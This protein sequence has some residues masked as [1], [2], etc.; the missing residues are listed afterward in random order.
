MAANLIIAAMGRSY[1]DEMVHANTPCHECMLTHMC[2][3]SS[4]IAR[5]TLIAFTTIQCLT[6][7]IT[8]TFFR[9]CPGSIRP[10]WI[11]TNVL[12]V[13][14]CK[15]GDPVAFSVLVEVNDALIHVTSK[16]YQAPEN[17]LA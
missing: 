10:R 9:L 12:V 7:R 5:L 4:K 3:W 1:K 15:F 14:A 13:T 2:V 17:L 16:A 11:V 6:K 8:S